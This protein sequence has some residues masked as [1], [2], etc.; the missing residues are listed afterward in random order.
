MLDFIKEKEQLS[1][2]ER[3][4]KA[5]QWDVDDKQKLERLIHDI[6][7]EVSDDSEL[8]VQRCCAKPDGVY[9]RLID[10]KTK[11]EETYYVIMRFFRFLAREIEFE[12]GA[13]IKRICGENLLHSLR[14]KHKIKEF[15][16][17][18]YACLGDV[19]DCHKGIERVPYHYEKDKYEWKKIFTKQVLPKL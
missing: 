8:N 19:F 4:L 1:T 13:L 9:I 16:E 14:G 18:Y 10:T 17:A 5:C 3:I 12:N 6:V 2:R 11:K 15:Y 7:I